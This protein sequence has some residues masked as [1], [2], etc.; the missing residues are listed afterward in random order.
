MTKL[1]A[2]LLACFS[3]V[4]CFSQMPTITLSGQENN[5]VKLQDLKINVQVLGNIAQ[6]K[7]N[8]VFCNSSAKILEGELNFPMPDGVSVS[9][10]ALDI[11]GKLRS[12]VVVENQRA[13]QVF[14]SIERR[15]VDP[16]LLEKTEGNN[17][18]TRI[19]PL[20]ANGCRTIE[21]G[22]NQVLTHFAAIRHQ[23]L[24]NKGFQFF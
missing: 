4:Y 24:V 3:T 12:A 8:M 5:S 9:H 6:V 16:G 20:P 18:R 14:E 11:N 17:Y 13:K 21:I 22:Y 2:L 23:T 19:Y 10:Y 7:M 1:T 15:R